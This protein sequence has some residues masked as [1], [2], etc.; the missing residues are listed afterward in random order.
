M[1]YIDRAM[2]MADHLPLTTPV[3]TINPETGHTMRGFIS[4]RYWAHQKYDLTFSNEQSK[5]GD[6][7]V[8]VWVDKSQFSVVGKPRNDIIKLPAYQAVAA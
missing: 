8:L 6:I 3:E 5:N 1:G 2:M 4:G 7:L